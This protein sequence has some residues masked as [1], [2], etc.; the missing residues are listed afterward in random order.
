MTNFEFI[1]IFLLTF[2][3]IYVIMLTAFVLYAVIS[4]KAIEKSTHNIEYVPL[5]PAWGTSEKDIGEINERSE[6]EFPDLDEDDL[7]FDKI[8]LNKVI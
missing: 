4:I 5:D 3:T 8:D 1:I 6:L 7:E 2:L